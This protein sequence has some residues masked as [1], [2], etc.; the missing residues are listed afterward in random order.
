VGDWVTIYPNATILGGETVIGSGSTIGANVF[1]M[2]SVPPNSLVR[3]ER[4]LLNIVSKKNR[5][6]SIARPLQGEI[7]PLLNYEI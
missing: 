7:E 1:L 3:N 4:A 2:E 6:Q 5:N